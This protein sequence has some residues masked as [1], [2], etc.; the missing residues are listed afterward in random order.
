[1][2]MASIKN[3]SKPEQI[4]QKF[5]WLLLHYLFYYFTSLKKQTRGKSPQLPSLYKEVKVNNRALSAQ[6]ITCS[7]WGAAASS[8]ANWLIAIVALKNCNKKTGKIR[9][10]H[11]AT[12]GLGTYSCIDCSG[13][14]ELTNSN[15][16]TKS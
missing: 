8:L 12:K 4:Q 3:H 16:S 5:H 1:M 9:D 2:L 6:N 14:S 7:W 13:S 10:L 15:C 11:Q